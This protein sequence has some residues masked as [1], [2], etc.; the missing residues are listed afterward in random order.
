MLLV[1]V[2]VDRWTV[3]AWPE[4][5]LSLVTMSSK[6]SCANVWHQ[7]CHILVIH[8]QGV[9]SIHFCLLDLQGEKRAQATPFSCIG[10]LFSISYVLLLLASG[11]WVYALL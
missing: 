1:F 11:K 5:V 3:Q 2:L 8:G 10:F 6:Y 9:Q 4:Q 7:T